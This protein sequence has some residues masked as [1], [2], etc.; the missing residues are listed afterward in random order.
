M[1]AAREISGLSTQ[2][3]KL[4]SAKKHN[5]A[6]ISVAIKLYKKTTLISSGYASMIIV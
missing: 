3:V 6:E 2:E 1:I 4:V 5:G